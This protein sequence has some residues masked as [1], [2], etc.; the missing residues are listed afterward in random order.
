MHAQSIRLDIDPGSKLT[1]NGTSNV[2]KWDCSTSSFNAV[3]DA[4]KSAAADV[5]KQIT[6]AKISIPV[7]SLE[8][9]EKKMNENMRKAMHADQHPN[10]DFTMSGYTATPAANGASAVVVKG[11]LTING[12][13]KP[14]AIKGTATPD[15]KGGVRLE[16][17][18]ELH[19]PDYGVARV[20]A[21]LGTIRTGEDVTIVLSLIASQPGTT[22]P[23]TTK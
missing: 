17:S 21:M 5:G 13:T 9:G 12:V 15:G 3:I 2:H 16:A 6:S 23:G 20:T 8:C 22:K 4:P 19:T 18:T 1:I 14:V 7:S 11:S 10:V